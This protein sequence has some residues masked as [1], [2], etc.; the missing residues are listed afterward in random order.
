[1]KPCPPDKERFLREARDLSNKRE[2]LLRVIVVQDPIS[3]PKKL[4]HLTYV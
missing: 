1:M 3:S 2:S 4:D